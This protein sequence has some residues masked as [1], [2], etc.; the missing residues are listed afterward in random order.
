MAENIKK[1]NEVR[2]QDFKYKSRAPYY[3]QIHH[4]NDN[5]LNLGYDYRGKIYR[6]NT[7]TEL[8]GNPLQIPFI[9]RLEAMITL[10]LEH[11][12]SIKKTFSIAH[13]KET[14]HIN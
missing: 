11:A 6:K 7:S 13:D 2:S 4:I 8:W 3:N 5:F 12:K 1:D 9:G 10:L 14:I